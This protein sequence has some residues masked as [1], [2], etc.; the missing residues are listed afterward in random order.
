MS[1][2]KAWSS[3]RILLGERLL[4]N[5]IE[6]ATLFRKISDPNPSDLFIAG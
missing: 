4:S 6:G 1:N 3:G 2:V 5:E